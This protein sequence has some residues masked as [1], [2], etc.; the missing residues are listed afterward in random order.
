[1]TSL[2]EQQLAQVVSEYENTLARSR[3][4]DASD[5]LSAVDVRDLQTRCLAA[6][7]RVSGRQSVYFQMADAVNREHDTHWDHLASQIGIARSLLSDVRNGYLKSFEEL[8]HGEVFGDFLEMA[9]H[10]AISGYK[11]AA[12]VVA[13]ATLESHLRSLS[14]KHGVAAQMGGV[15]KKADALNAELVKAGAYSKLDQKNVTAWLGLRMMQ[16]T[17]TMLHMTRIK[18]RYSSAASAIS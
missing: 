3:H 13:G 18:L 6:I 11:D 17:G 4:T 8:I 15:P 2:L 5:I 9:A 12:A 16:L 14:A 1:M 7:E 10:L